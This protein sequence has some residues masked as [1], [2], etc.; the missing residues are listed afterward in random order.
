M[1]VAAPARGGLCPAGQWAR[2]APGSPGI[3]PWPV[4]HRL[5]PAPNAQQLTVCISPCTGSLHGAPPSI[6]RSTRRCLGPTSGRFSSGRGAAAAAAVP[7][8]PKAGAGNWWA[9]PY[10]AAA[11]WGSTRCRWGGWAIA[12]GRVVARWRALPLCPGRA[13]AILLLPCAFTA[14]HSPNPPSEASASFVNRARAWW[15]DFVRQCAGFK[16]RPVKV[17]LHLMPWSTGR[18]L[19]WN[20]PSKRVDWSGPRPSVSCICMSACAVGAL[21]CWAGEAHEMRASRMRRCRLPGP[22]FS[23]LSTFSSQKSITGLSSSKAL[24]APTAIEAGACTRGGWRTLPFVCLCAPAPAGKAAAYALPCR[25]LGGAAQEAR[26]GCCGRR[27]LHSSAASG[28]KWAHGWK[29]T[30]W[31][32]WQIR[33]VSLTHS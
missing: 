31:A 32:R 1:L 21:Q 30:L 11:Q 7:P 25:A 4:S 5:G 6:L 19:T 23:S 33:A 26:W 12:R 24:C 2:W 9:T 17:G 18:L 20:V 8:I 3:R 15:A 13:E 29:L 28:C 16:L 10:S 22:F 14:T 27:Q